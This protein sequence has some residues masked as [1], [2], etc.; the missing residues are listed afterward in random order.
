MPACEK[1]PARRADAYFLVEK[2]AVMLYNIKI[3]ILL[4]EIVSWFVCFLCATAGVPCSRQIEIECGKSRQTAATAGIDYYRFTT[5]RRTESIICIKEIGGAGV[6][7]SGNADLCFSLA[8]VQTLPRASFR[9]RP[10]QQ[11]ARA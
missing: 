6:I 4:K 3:I 10:S 8:C 9:D 1:P 7:S 2:N 11:Q 5:V